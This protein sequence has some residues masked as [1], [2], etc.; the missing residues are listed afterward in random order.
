MNKTM[1]K[2]T[3]SSLTLLLSTSILGISVNAQNK[4]NNKDQYP[5]TPKEKITFLKSLS[6]RLAKD[7]YTYK[8]YKV[9]YNDKN[10][11]VEVLQSKRKTDYKVKGVWSYSGATFSEGVKLVSKKGKEITVSMIDGFY[12][13]NA[14]IK[15]LKNIIK[16][17]TSIMKSQNKRLIKKDFIKL[18]KM[19]SYINSAKDKKIAKQ[20]YEQ[21]KSYVKDNSN[22]V[23][24]LL[25]GQI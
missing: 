6:E 19:I 10:D 12:N 20:S 2:I 23:P 17:E 4:Q 24:S 3:V 5:K 1:K 8:P 25:V 21:L 11:S 7:G 15:S 22:G 13:K 18:E 16:L 14:N 9:N